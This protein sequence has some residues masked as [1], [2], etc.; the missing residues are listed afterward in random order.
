MLFSFAIFPFLCIL[1]AMFNGKFKNIIILFLIVLTS[2]I[3]SSRIIGSSYS[4]D[5][6]EYYWYL[7]FAS[8]VSVKYFILNTSFEPLFALLHYFLSFFSVDISG[9]LFFYALI[10][11]IFFSL[12]INRLSIYRLSLICVVLVLINTSLMFFET[13]LIRQILAIS[14][15]LYAITFEND[16]RFYFWFVISCGFHLSVTVFFVCYKLGRFLLSLHLKKRIALFVLF[17]SSG[18]V[19]FSYLFP[20]IIDFLSTLT[21]ILASKS[22]YYDNELTTDIKLSN[23]FLY[24]FPAFVILFF[25]WGANEQFNKIAGLFLGVFLLSFSLFFSPQLSERFFVLC[26]II[27][28]LVVFYLFMAR[29]NEVSLYKYGIGYFFVMF[30]V[31]KFYFGVFFSIS[32]F[33]LFGGEYYKD[34][35]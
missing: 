26:I 24:G 29:V 10:T 4:D 8:S 23:Y 32:D 20:F 9:M 2:F 21:L 6:I 17:F 28:P 5:A 13:Q 12:A 18:F 16:R 15:F 25:N 14:I 3:A 1:D 27:C 7:D 19:V 34:L 22:Q 33:S 35:F 30:I 31:L 11:N